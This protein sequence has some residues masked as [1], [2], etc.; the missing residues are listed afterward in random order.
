VQENLATLRRRGVL[1]LEPDVGPLAGGDVGAGR[2][3]DAE[4]IFEIIDNIVRA[5]QSGPLGGTTVVIT[6]GGTREAIDPVRV[7]TNRSSGKQGYALAEVAARLGARVE[8][9]TTV[10]RSLAVDTQRRITVTAVETASEM[11][12]VVMSL[13]PSADIVIM[14]A[15]VSDFT[16]TP[17]SG[18]IKKTEG[19]P[20]LRLTPTVD[21]LSELLATRRA[22]Q[23]IV[24]FAAETDD[25]V[26][27]A[28]AKLR[29]KPVD[30]LV[31][32]DVSQEGVGFE[33]STNSVTLFTRTGEM[34][35]LPLQS[36]NDIAYEILTNVSSLLGQ[37]AP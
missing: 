26:A 37:G 4:R 18:K 14:A 23:V 35:H 21:I 36:K 32:N 19:V 28:Q 20:E 33:H 2:L 3:P 25:V 11:H 10:S 34:R 13:A 30:L 12:A 24:G 31:M 27:H 16:L 15:A 7:I 6:A 9:V 8:L 1:V 17:S 22:D 29:R 5:G